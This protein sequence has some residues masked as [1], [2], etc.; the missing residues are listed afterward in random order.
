MPL[1]YYD[2]LGRRDQAIYRASDKVARIEVPDTG[3]LRGV[4]AALERSLDAGDRLQVERI[5]A[6][7]LDGL[8]DRLRVARVRVRVLAVRPSDNSG[9]LHGLYER[10]EGETA[11]VS[12]WM[13]TA[14][15]RQVVRFRTFLRTLVHEFCHH[16]DYE[17]LH[18]ADSFHT[19][20][21]FKRES[22][23]VRQLGGGDRPASRATTKPPPALPARSADNDAR[24]ASALARCREL[25]GD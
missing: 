7:L 1:A 19:E 17:H 3:P 14:R 22:A 16:L 23:L 15:N 11:V 20:G 8:A 2:K 13:R 21:F 5:A 6:S 9:E 18:L 12:V 4:T 25:L 24:A 10:T